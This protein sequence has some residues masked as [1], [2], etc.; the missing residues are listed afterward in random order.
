MMGKVI[1]VIWLGSC[2]ADLTSTHTAI[3]HGAHE[4]DPMLPANGVGRDVLLGGGCTVAAAEVAAL[5]AS[6]P[7][8][9]WLLTIGNAVT[10]G[11]ASA[12]NLSLPH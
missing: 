10:H 4:L 11:W 1:F 3:H 5:S 6:H 2:G 8:L 9:A 7:K 12:H